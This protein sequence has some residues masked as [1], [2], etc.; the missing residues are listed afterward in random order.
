[1][2]FSP[3]PERTVLRVA[4]LVGGLR[5][6]VEARYG[7][8]WVEGE[9][10]NFRRYRSG[11]CYF[12]LKDADAQLRGVLFRGH[13]RGVFFEPQDGM[14]VRAHGAA[15][16]YEPRGE[17]QL[18]V[19]AM[20]LAGEGALR[21]AFEA[22][23]AKLEAEGLFDPARKRPLPP[24]PEVVGVVTSGDGAAL[25]DVLSVLGR[26][27]PQVRVLVC[28][29]RVQGMGAAA[30]IA[31]AV[32]AFNAVP[33]GHTLRADVLIV[34]RGG[35]S[36]EDLWC[37]SEEAV[38][39]AVAASTIP[40][41]SAV[42][43]ETDVAI[44]DFAADVRAATPSMAAELV[45]PDRRD[46]AALVHGFY[47][48]LHDH[49]HGE[50]EARRQRI[51]VLTGSYAFRRPPER[52][53]LAQQ[54]LDDLAAR[55]HAAA[56]RRVQAERRRAEAAHDRLRLL[57]PGRPLRLGYARVERDGRALRRA[58]D[59]APGDAL[60]L[61]FADGTRAARVEEDEG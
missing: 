48:A 60:T 23:K 54:R 45:A 51:G 26:R 19:R 59:L 30:E 5:D 12:T 28:P 4:D 39:R 46:V 29:V 25:H 1:M 34:G 40:V 20:E 58:A 27:F 49:A 52:L 50:I 36:A 31:E 3:P 61:R 22:L 44:S 42:G 24:Y 2:D 57:D 8:V 9:L 43:H 55:L 33:P 6:A 14:L 15:S 35:G 38:A 53:R 41:V 21:Q 10:S 47:A 37:F 11:H 32:E 18:V 13:A 56:R 17:L 16:V 7:D